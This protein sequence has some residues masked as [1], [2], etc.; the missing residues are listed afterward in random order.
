MAIPTRRHLRPIHVRRELKAFEPVWEK[1]GYERWAQAF[2]AKNHWRVQYL[3]PER[4]DAV[5]ECA[6]IFTQ[7][8]NKYRHT[9]NRTPDYQGDRLMNDK[10]FMKLFISSV[11]NRWCRLS[12]WDA[13]E[14]NLWISDSIGIDD[15]DVRE[16]ID[17][18]FAS[19]LNKA[20]HEVPGFTDVNG[21]PLAVAISELPSEVR[22]VFNRLIAAPDEF[23]AFLFGG[24]VNVTTADEASLAA[25][26]RRLRHFFGLPHM[27]FN[28]LAP[29]IRQLRTLLALR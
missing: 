25:L 28:G 29:L 14:R 18:P 15:R 8:R 27:P 4:K 3:F 5:Q 9:V 22:S 26:D 24:S 17:D 6:V 21:G 23:L 10:W 11:S 16:G 13:R 1:S 12:Q 20:V 7:C 2:V 19:A